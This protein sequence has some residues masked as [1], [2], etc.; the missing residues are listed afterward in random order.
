MTK[1]PGRP[2]NNKDVRLKLLQQARILFAKKGYAKVTTR[3]IA[4]AAKTDAAMIR[5]YF[6]SKENLFRTVIK[7]TVQPLLTRIRD[8]KSKGQTISPQELIALYYSLLSET[9][10]LPKLIFR[11]IH[12]PDAVEHDIVNNVFSEL[13]AYRAT[14]LKNSIE[15]NSNISSS[16]NPVHILISTLSL[17]VFPFLLPDDLKQELGIVVNKEFLTELSQHHALLLEHGI[18]NKVSE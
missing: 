8:D 4:E 18:A 3:M 6:G 16:F 13:M 12:D 15:N 2:S 7:E 5:Y 10:D 14:Q 11:S 9:P 17:S 1:M